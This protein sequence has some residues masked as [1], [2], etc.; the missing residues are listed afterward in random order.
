MGNDACTES[1]PPPEPPQGLF[2][3]ALTMK[4]AQGFLLTFL[5]IPASRKVDDAL[6]ISRSSLLWS[7]LRSS[8]K[9]IFPA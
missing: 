3:A 7:L 2:F 5:C 6:D 4:C 1:A 9:A 8:Q